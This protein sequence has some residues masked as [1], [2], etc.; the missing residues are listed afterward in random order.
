MATVAVFSDADRGALH[1]Q[2]A[3][4]AVHLGGAPAGESYLNINQIIAVALR[5]GATAIHPG[6][7]FLSENAT[8]AAACV[9]AGISFIGPSARAIEAMGS[10]VTAKQIVEAAGVPLL[11]G[12]HGANQDDDF[13][14]RQAAEIGYPVLL[15]AALGG[16]GKGM[17]VV[18]G[19]D[20]FQAALEAA[21]REA[22]GAFGDDLMLIEKYLIEPRHIEVQIFC[23]Q[24]GNGVFLNERDCSIQRRHQKII[25]E[26][27]ALGIGAELRRE[28]GDTALRC[29]Q[30]IDYTGAG[31][32]EF[33]LDTNGG[34]YFMEMNTRL[35]VEHPVTEMITGF[36]LVEWQLR[37]AAGERLPVSQETVPLRGHAIEARIYAEDPKQGFLPQTGRISFLQAPTAAEFVRVDTGVKQGDEISIHYDPM[38]AKLIVHDEDRDRALARL[39]KA[40][41]EYRIG[42]VRTNVGFLHNLVR[43]AGFQRGALATSFIHK[44]EAALFRVP[45]ADAKFALAA[46]SLHRLLQDR[47]GVRPAT[48]DPHSPWLDVTGWTLNGGQVRRLNLDLEG[49]A[50][51]VELECLGGDRYAM[52]HAGDHCLLEGRQDGNLITLRMDGH[53]RQLTVADEGDAITVFVS[54]HGFRCKAIKPDFRAADQLVR[55][56]DLTAPMSG[57]IVFL[58]ANEGDRVAAGAALVVLE[59]M[60]M[61][62]TIKA[63]AA[64]RVVSFH[65]GPGDLVDGGATLLDFEPE[66]QGRRDQ[67]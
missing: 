25:E 26:A 62:H 34:Y 4:E 23:D 11:P 30:V 44:H 61:E 31:T 53:R 6:Y 17:R 42:G 52:T 58:A 16:G 50:L 41:D 39:A 12:Y 19:D 33:L 43:S 40:L 65:F 48:A 1:V 9:N 35:Q 47:A 29:A 2:M 22:S 45:E 57:R 64:G 37:I 60:K 63:P 51:E 21:R 55:D 13:L 3:D 32:V 49:E 10:K 28:M 38:L 8:F 15:K 36:D 5:A 66:D 14:R 24:F 56:A 46:A 54:G 7:G 18:E 20:A 67:A 27:P 59:A